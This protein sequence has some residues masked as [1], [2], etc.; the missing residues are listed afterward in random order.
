MRILIA[1]KDPER[2]ELYRRILEKD[3]YSVLIAKNRIEVLRDYKTQSIDAVVIDLGMPHAFDT[4]RNIKDVPK[5][6]VSGRPEDEANAKEF[7]ADYFITRAFTN[8]KDLSDA[9]R[10]VTKKEPVKV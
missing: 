5:V 4:I 7:G 6:V 10:Y 1:D 2:L 9:V 3:Q 8:I